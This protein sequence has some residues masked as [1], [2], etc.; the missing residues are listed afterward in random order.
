MKKEILILL[1]LFLC[2][3]ACNQ[4]DNA[5]TNNDSYA[6]EHEGIIANITKPKDAG[7]AQDGGYRMLVIADI[8][9]ED[10]SGKTNDELTALAQE[11]DGARYD[12][13]SDMYD[14]EELELNEGLKVT[15]YWNG[16]EGESD[17]PVRE[18]EKIDV[19]SE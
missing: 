5:N 19:M 16:N 4:N 8:D 14:E 3:G 6:E 9:D 17:P 7:D 12:V 18:A 2:L 13:N 11:K 15:I 10:I 1:V